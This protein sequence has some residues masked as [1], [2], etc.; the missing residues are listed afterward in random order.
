MTAPTRPTD[1]G[2]VGAVHP[3]EREPPLPPGARVGRYEIE[4]LIGAGGMGVVYAAHDPQL[5]RRV[6]LKL[7]R[8]D[9]WNAGQLDDGRTRLLREA[10]PRRLLIFER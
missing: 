10:L 8:R 4:R 7:L 2:L 3:G 5:D 6:A 9:L 1:L